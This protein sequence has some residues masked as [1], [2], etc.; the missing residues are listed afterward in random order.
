MAT[1]FLSNSDKTWFQDSADSWF[2][3]FKSRITV[4]KEPIKNISANNSPFL[5]YEP[6]TS[7]Q[8][9]TYTPRNEDFDAVVKYEDPKA[10]E[11]I[12]EVKSKFTNQPVSI[13]VKKDARDYIINDVTIKII[14][15]DK[16]FNVMSSDVIRNYF[17]TIYY[18]FYLEETK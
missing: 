13:Q 2:E 10:V 9:V 1:S 6:D 8:E 7:I 17:N 4:V 11:S 18:V 3:T 15:Q 14:Y 12:P 16:S 5:G